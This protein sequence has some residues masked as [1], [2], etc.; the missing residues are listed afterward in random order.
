[1]ADTSEATSDPLELE[2]IEERH[3]QCMREL[4]ALR[5]RLHAL[6]AV[7]E[8]ALSGLELD[9]LLRAALA[10]VR[11]LLAAD[12]ATVLLQTEDGRYLT[13]YASSGLGQEVE[14]G[15]QIP[16]G[17]GVAGRILARREP[18]VEEDLPAADAA[19]LLL[20][21]GVRSVA[22]APLVVR[23]RPIGA[24]LVGSPQPRRFSPED[25][26]P[27]RLVAGQ[28]ALAID[29]ARLVAAERQARR[30]ITN[31]LES[32]TDAFFTLDRQ[33]RFTYVN[34][35]AERL[36]ARRREEL[37]GRSVWSAFPEA[38]GGPFYQA[39]HRAMAEQKTEV[40]EAYYPPLGRWFEARAFPTPG[41]LSVFFRDV[42]E[43]RRAEEER[44][45]LLADVERRATMLDAVIESTDAQ[46]AL[47]APDFTFILVNSAYAT[48]SGHTKEE[49][50][51]RNHF[52]LF[53]NPENQA[54]FERV[55]D[56]GRPYKAIEKPF[57]FADQPE[58]GVTYWNWILVPVKGRAGQV[59]ALLLS[60]LDVTPQVRA[61]QRLEALSRETEQRAAELQATLDAISSGLV[62]LGPN[63]EL[64]RM[65]RAAERL[66]GMTT[67]EWTRLPP[68]ERSRLIRA[69]APDGRPLAF[70]ETPSYLAEHGQE[71]VGFRMALR[72]ADGSRRHVL[73]SA[74]PIRNAEGR[75]TGAVV[76]WADVT[77]LV[78][79]QE[80]REDIL[81][82]VSHDLR[83]PL[84]GILGQAQL[85]ER[86][87]AKAGM[88]RERTSAE[89]IIAAAQRMDTMIQDLVD[90][91][92]S[93]AGQI[94]LERQPI[95]MHAFALDLKERLA[96]TL[97]TAR[98]EIRL[99]AGLPPISADPNRLERI[100]TNL[101][102]NALKYSA[103]GTPVAVTA[104]QEDGWLVT[105]VSD[106]GPG[107]PPEHLGR[108]FERYFRGNAGREGVGLGLYITKR[109]VE[110]HGGRIWAE[111]EV[112]AGST[113][114]FTLPIAS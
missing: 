49:L 24:L 101:W 46:L 105:A 58:R 48:A 68:R 110:A 99:P 102:S 44:E 42:S 7:G 106:R 94:R 12:T 90:A 22:G 61:R 111:S 32:I 25:L 2:R 91:A 56:T 98:I 26:Q 13:P 30:Q 107:I 8:V 3:A 39:Y 28:V 104:R 18:V 57:E 92:R 69:E 4:A 31:V 10:R 37:L 78:E 71:V 5:A 62:I 89:R 9:D 23:G 52:A 88:E 75:V 15:V 87:L 14:Q 60:L 109:L 83:N 50:I 85:C 43:R 40:V 20:G 59:E 29:N 17:R 64:V 51:G 53:P 112:G 47:L 93:E 95:D 35:E 63:D 54:I 84:A 80:Q 21:E 16:V 82:A 103:P 70:E 65:N 1:M 108:L 27:L 72:R 73:A 79:L 66:V 81:R 11:E 6:E 41:G 34:D 45:R 100:L 55:R 77:P 19:G 113:F 86:R 67:E 74:G 38:V 33:W 114:S 36:L 96:H 97:E 76:N